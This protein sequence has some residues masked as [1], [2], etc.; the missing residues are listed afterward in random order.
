[1]PH[2]ESLDV[3]LVDERLVERH[4]RAAVVAPVEVRA[5]DD[6]AGHRGRA[7][8]FV[9]GAVGIVEA[10]GKD[11]FAPLDGALDRA[12]VRVQQE[13]RGE[14]TV[15]FGGVP[16]T[17][18]AIPVAL[19]GNDVRQVP[20]PA[21]RGHLAEVGAL[22]VPIFIEETELHPLRDLGEDREVGADAVVHRT[23]RVRFSRPRLRHSSPIP[24]RARRP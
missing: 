5:G 2:G 24:P 15:P 9:R 8:G 10:M 14:A 19:S 4:V 13:L 18:D 23:Q 7:V 17:V 16:G 21:E 6:A 22:L 3:H 11:R 12:R 20:V 1:M